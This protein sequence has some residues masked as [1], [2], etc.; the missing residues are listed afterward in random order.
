V[1]YEVAKALG[2]P[3]DVYV[4]RKLGVPGHEELALGAI[5]SHDTYHLNYDVIDALNV[6]R[7]EIL[8]VVAREREELNRRDRA[9]RDGRP[10]PEIAG[11]TVI[12]VDDG[13]ATGASM[14]A[15]VAALRHDDPARIVV[16]VPV[17]AAETCAR[18]REKAD[19]VVICE[20]PDPFGGV[21]A[22]YEHFPQLSDEDV[23]ALLGRATAPA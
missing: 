2:A 9:Y 12:L 4:V 20:T 15:A 10:R 21:G 1:A 18:L 8:R 16:G 3:L 17:G 14:F 22:W 13:L 19:E 6:T 11:K 23:C 7:R 5:G